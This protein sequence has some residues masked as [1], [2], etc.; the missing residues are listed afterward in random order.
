MIELDIKNKNQL[1]QLIVGILGFTAIVVACLVIMAPFFPGILL[2]TM[3]ALSTW[4]AFTWLSK[5]LNGRTAWAALLMTLMLAGFFILP[6]VIIGT[7][8][9]E[10]FTKIYS[11]VQTSLKG[12][13]ETMAASLREIDYVGEYLEKVWLFFIQDGEKLS[14]S[15]QQYAAPTSQELIRLG[16][17]IGY[18]L[19]DITLGVILAYFCFRHGTNAAN[20]LSTLIDKFAGERGRNIIDISTSTLTSVIYGILGTALAQGLLATFGFWLAGIPGAAFLGLVTFFLSFIPMGPPL[21]WLPAV[22][23]LY[24]S[25]E[26]AWSMFLFLWGIFVISSVDNFLKPYFISLGSNLPLMLVLLGVLGGVLAFGFVGVFIGP[27]FLA[28]AYS[29]IMEWSAMRESK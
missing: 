9:K 13:T 14:A 5:K 8:I 17:S 18:G 22:V 15:L 1:Y 28:V 2:A 27:T 12:N 7:S 21:L 25:G 3:F 29:L 11:F 4:P 23:W 16:A 20:R 6:V 24:T 26:Q 19:L 10:N